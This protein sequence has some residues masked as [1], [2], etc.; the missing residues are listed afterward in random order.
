MLNT[1]H[2]LE[3]RDF[4]D[5]LKQQLKRWGREVSILLDDVDRAESA[6]QSEYRELLRDLEIDFEE[7][8]LRADEIESMSES[9]FQEI[10]TILED[11]VELFLEEIKDAR[12][13][14]QDV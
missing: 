14:I 8:E 5:T 9:E 7:L 2:V 4:L 10:Y 6:R 3:R 1:Y 12:A 13:T 11:E